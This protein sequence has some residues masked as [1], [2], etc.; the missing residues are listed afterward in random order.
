M[1]AALITLLSVL[2]LEMAAIGWELRIGNRYDLQSSKTDHG[3]LWIKL[4]K[5][6]GQTWYA[7]S[8]ASVQPQTISS[9]AP[10]DGT[11]TPAATATLAAATPT[12]T[13]SVDT[14]A[15]ASTPAT[16][17]TPAPAPNTDAQ[18][19]TTMAE[20]NTAPTTPPPSERPA[21]KSKKPKRKK[22]TA[23]Q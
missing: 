10:V 7:N 9:W 1:K 6:T 21:K 22:D 4:D 2:V 15:S 3:A 18:P 12:P 16:D 19:V 8:D 20:E 11:N 14:T 17:P 5:R 13:P 23:P